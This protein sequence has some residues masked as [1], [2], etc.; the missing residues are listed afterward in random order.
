MTL[1]FASV[2]A[3]GRCSRLTASCSFLFAPDVSLRRLDGSVPE[4]KTNLFKFAVA[5][6]AES[7]TGTTKIV[8]RQI[9]DASLSRTPLDRIPDHVGRHASFL[10]FPLLRNPS[11]LPDYEKE[12]RALA[13]NE[14][15]VICGLFS[16]CL[17]D[18][19]SQY[20]AALGFTVVFSRPPTRSQVHGHR[21][22]FRW[23]C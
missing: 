20:V 16:P 6:V 18:E 15:C 10:S 7:G 21:V 8:R 3:G 19:S 12:N 22:E 17:C 1:G 23:G 9:R 2:S 5:I 4:Q 11:E 13:R 14:I